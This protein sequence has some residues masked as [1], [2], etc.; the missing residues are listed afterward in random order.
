M[1]RLAEAQQQVQMLL[2]DLNSSLAKKLPN[3]QLQEPEA[4]QALLESLYTIEG[5]ATRNKEEFQHKLAGK[6]RC[7][8]ADVLLLLEGK[9]YKQKKREMEQA[10]EFSISDND[11]ELMP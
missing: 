8:I 10:R 5:R 6:L 2:N 3:S 11:E 4:L 1:D 7:A 9:D